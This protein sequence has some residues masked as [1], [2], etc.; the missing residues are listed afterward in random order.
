MLNWFEGKKTKIGLAIILGLR[1][2]ISNGID[3]PAWVELVVYGITGLSGI[4]HADRWIS[5]LSK[6]K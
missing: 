2:A 3:I 6:K 5:S 1:V 4:G